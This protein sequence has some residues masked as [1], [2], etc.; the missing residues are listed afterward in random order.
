MRELSANLIN[1][2]QKLWVKKKY[3]VFLI[4]E[5]AICA[6]VVFVQ[7][8][9]SRAS[10]GIFPLRAM[11]L[12]MTVITFFIEVLIPLIVFMAA[13]DLFCT[14]FQDKTM[15]AVIVRPISKFKIYLSKVLAVTILASLNIIAVF[16]VTNL[17]E[18]TVVGEINNFWHSFGAYFLNILPMFIVVLMAV[19][20]NQTVNG[21][22]LAM[23]ICIIAYAALK[24]SV[25]FIPQLGGLLF[26]GYMQWHKLWL[27]Q[28]LPAGA[29][30]SKIALLFGYII[31]FLSG[32]YYLFDKREF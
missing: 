28:M 1:E 23:F 20:L 24:L 31:V 11:S 3:I 7:T 10:N 29:L 5:V 9:I 8:L 18:A 32:G 13:T 26:T 2:L 27:G 17:L 22:T 19:L 14:E 16:L 21:S 30:F 25:F 4:I 6:L 15:R 12:S